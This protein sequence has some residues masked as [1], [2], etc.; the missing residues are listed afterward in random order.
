MSQ[1]GTDNV[2]MGHSILEMG[3]QME[4]YPVGVKYFVLPLR[5]SGNDIR[6]LL[7]Y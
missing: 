2:P 1:M 7:R 4:N 5:G 3:F 6:N